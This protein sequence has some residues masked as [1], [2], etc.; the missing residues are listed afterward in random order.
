MSSPTKAQKFAKLSTNDDSI[1]SEELAAGGKQAAAAAGTTATQ[2]RWRNFL[3]FFLAADVASTVGLYETT[4][5]FAPSWSLT[6]IAGF[7]S[8]TLDL[9]LL[10]SLRVLAFSL[11]V[12]LTLCIGIDSGPAGKLPHE[13]TDAQLAKTARSGRVRVLLLIGM[14][15]LGAASSVFAGI[16]CIMFD[17][18]TTENGISAE[19][20][21]APFLLVHCSLQCSLQDPPPIQ[22]ILARP[23]LQ[24]PENRLVTLRSA[25]TG[26]RRTLQWSTCSSRASSASSSPTSCRSAPASTQTS[27]PILLACCP[28]LPSLSPSSAGRSD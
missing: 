16:K 20:Y 23:R 5:A 17:F 2:T 13:Q 24:Q 10:A 12:P 9:V 18:I 8:D 28:G 22:N 11:L 19:T 6:D 4:H 26:C 27:P 7:R 14:F 15:V 25:A 1:Y 21:M 3:L